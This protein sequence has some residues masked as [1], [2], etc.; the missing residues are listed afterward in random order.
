[1]TAVVTLG[2]SANAPC[3]KCGQPVTFFSGEKD[4]FISEVKNFASDTV[5]QLECKV[6]G[7]F[8][9]RAGDFRNRLD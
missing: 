2:G 3:P 8:E 9:V 1:M 5:R 6:H 7:V 4:A